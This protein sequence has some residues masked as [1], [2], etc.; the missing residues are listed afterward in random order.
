MRGSGALRDVVYSYA[1]GEEV[2]AV[3][4]SV[5]TAGSA[6]ASLMVYGE[7]TLSMDAQGCVIGGQPVAGTAQGPTRVACMM[8]G[9]LRGEG[10][11]MVSVGGSSQSGPDGARVLVQPAG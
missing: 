11:A 5:V 1:S 8:T 9:A 3:V 2:R 7:P 6:G 4:P 10:F